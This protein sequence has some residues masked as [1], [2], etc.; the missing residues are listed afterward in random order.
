M[1]TVTDGTTSAST[2]FSWTVQPAPP[3]CPPITVCIE[4]LLALWP[5]RSQSRWHSMR[6]LHL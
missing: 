1:V 4:P 2:T 5:T 6:G 3:S